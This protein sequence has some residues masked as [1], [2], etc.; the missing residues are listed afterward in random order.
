LLLTPAPVTARLARAANY[1]F[2]AAN[3]QPAQAFMLRKSG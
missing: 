2:G 3:C 1:P